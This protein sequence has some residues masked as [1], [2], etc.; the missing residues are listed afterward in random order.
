MDVRIAATCLF[1]QFNSD[2]TIEFSLEFYMENNLFQ[3]V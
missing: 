1:K 2:K 3:F